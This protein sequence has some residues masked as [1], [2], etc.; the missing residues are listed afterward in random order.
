MNLRPYQET[1]ISM[2]GENFRKGILRQLFCLPTGG[3]KTVVF[4]AMSHR[5]IEKGNRVL[6][7][8]DRLELL[9]QAGGTLAKFG[10]HPTL[11]SASQKHLATSQL[12]VA[13]AETLYRRINRVSFRRAL[14]KIDLMIIDEAHKGFARKIIEAMPDTRVIGATATP[15]S[16]SK[17]LPLKG[18]YEEIVEPVKI[19]D[20][21]ADGY[22]VHAKTFAAKEEVAKLKVK[23]GE[24]TDESQMEHF[25]RSQ[26]YAGVIE[27]YN[28][29]SLGTKALCFNVNIDHGQ[30]M[31]QAFRDSGI[32]A[33]HLDGTTP[34]HT[35]ERIL[36]DFSAGAFQVLC[37]VGV[38][39]TGF[40]EPSVQ[41][42]ILNRKTKSLPLYLQMCGRGSRLFA[43]KQHFTIIDMG[44]NFREHGLWQQDTDWKEL[45]HN[46]PKPGQTS[47]SSESPT[48]DCPQCQ[49]VMA[50]GARKCVRCGYAFP[51]PEPEYLQSS[52]FVEVTL[53]EWLNYDLTKKPEDMGVKELE[54]LQQAKGYKAGWLFRQL[55][56]RGT[57]ALKE[58][59]SLKGYKAGWV[60]H[61]LS[62]R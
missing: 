41:T 49:Y 7:C 21:I 14:G 16:S 39:T 27:N 2:L 18:I 31:C 43:D 44:S 13:M 4:S 24:Y 36:K 58:Y 62:L 6:I 40:D 53:D 42:I 23:N 57:D 28:Q 8:T 3:G 50:T 45:F 30:K 5:A 60:Q 54:F 48:K 34:K 35:R 11:I 38:L 26:I 32:T 25:G 51:D 55:R 46:P 61:Q 33:Q 10:M 19:S 59:A 56:Q 17:K 47:D 20:L 12:Y 37:N 22:L 29:L 52:E 1:G 15:L 9:T